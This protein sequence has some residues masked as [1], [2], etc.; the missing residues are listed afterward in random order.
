[1]F[2]KLLKMLIS[3]EPKPNV[4]VLERVE[5]NANT[6]GTLTVRPRLPRQR[7]GCVSLGFLYRVLYLTSMRSAD[8][9]RRM[10]TNLA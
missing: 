10:K 2:S 7:S 9:L 1:M 3:R 4:D 5:L 6:N 8:G